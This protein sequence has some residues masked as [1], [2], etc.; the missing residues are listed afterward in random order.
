MRAWYFTECFDAIFVAKLV[1]SSQRNLWGVKLNSMT[2]SETFADLF[3][4]TYF[5][6]HYCLHVNI[7]DKTTVSEKAYFIVI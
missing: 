4:T 3:A 7:M 6:Y 1:M 5:I 2:S